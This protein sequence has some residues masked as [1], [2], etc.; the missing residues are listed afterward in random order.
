MRVPG[1]W[2]RSVW[3]SDVVTRDRVPQESVE[4]AET[5]IIVCLVLHTTSVFAVKSQE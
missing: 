3:P 5:L 4:G 2:L 1:A